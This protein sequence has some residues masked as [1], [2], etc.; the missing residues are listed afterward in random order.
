MIVGPFAA[1]LATAAASA[2]DAG[3]AMTSRAIS[4]TSV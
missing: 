1:G 3:I 4:E 2:G